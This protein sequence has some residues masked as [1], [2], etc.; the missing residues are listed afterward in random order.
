MMILLVGCAG[1]S[2]GVRSSLLDMEVRLASPMFA[3]DPGLAVVYPAGRG[4]LGQDPAAS[5]D[6]ARAF[7]PAWRNLEGDHPSYNFNP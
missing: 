2:G 3:D 5:H 7:G 6:L 1:C 4:A